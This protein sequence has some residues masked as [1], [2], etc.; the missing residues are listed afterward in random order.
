MADGEQ[1]AIFFTVSIASILMGLMYFVFRD[2]ETLSRVGS[3]KARLAQ[4]FASYR[5]VLKNRNMVLITLVF[6]VGGA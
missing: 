1:V 4:G 6:M 5:R 2:Y 3:G